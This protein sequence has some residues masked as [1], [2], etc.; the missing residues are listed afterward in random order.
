M[1]LSLYITYS[2][3]FPSAGLLGTCNTWTSCITSTLLEL[4]DEDMSREPLLLIWVVLLIRYTEAAMQVTAPPPQLAPE[5]TSETPTPGP[6]V[7]LDPSPAQELVV[8]LS[9][10]LA[11]QH[12]VVQSLIWVVEHQVRGR[13]QI[14]GRAPG[15]GQSSVVESPGEWWEDLPKRTAGRV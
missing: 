1:S 12:Q 8:R 4:V 7:P 2:T 15:E 11:M 14:G 5:A 3:S 13:A 6:S 9:H 10:N